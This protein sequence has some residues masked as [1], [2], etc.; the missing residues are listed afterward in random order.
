M[1]LDLNCTLG[2]RHTARR[3]L[4]RGVSEERHDAKRK[5]FRTNA[6]A[7]VV[8]QAGERVTREAGDVGLACHERQPDGT[9]DRFAPKVDAICVSERDGL[10]Q[11]RGGRQRRLEKRCVE[12]I[13]VGAYRIG[14][15]LDFALVENV[16]LYRQHVEAALDDERELAGT[17]LEPG[18]E[19]RRLEGTAIVREPCDAARRA[20]GAKGNAQQLEELSAVAFGDLVRT[21]QQALCEESE[22]LDERHAGVALAEIRPFRI[23]HCRATEPFVAK[24]LIPAVVDERDG[25]WHDDILMRP[26]AR[27]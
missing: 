22:H 21:I 16:P 3:Q 17:Q 27:R 7:Y 25:Q 11:P 4:S 14:G 10:I 9:V 5:R 23:V 2:I 18:I 8:E 20:R 24:I 19:C 12:L 13:V 26:R 15:L 1:A 6:I